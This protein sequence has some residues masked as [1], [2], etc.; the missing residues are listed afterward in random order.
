MT[1]AEE[2]D[3]PKYCLRASCHA[4]SARQAERG[5]DLHERGPVVPR[6]RQVEEPFWGDFP[7]VGQ[8]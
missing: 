3:Q 4:S 2:G 1:M 6:K 5:V 8:Q 7:W